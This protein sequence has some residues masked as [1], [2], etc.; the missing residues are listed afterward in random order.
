MWERERL[1]KPYEIGIQQRMFAAAIEMLRCDTFLQTVREASQLTTKEIKIWSHEG[2]IYRKKRSFDEG[3]YAYSVL[4][5]RIPHAC[6][7]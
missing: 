4:F 6:Y 5:V 7:R 1:S 3:N 2:F